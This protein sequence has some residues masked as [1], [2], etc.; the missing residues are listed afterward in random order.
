MKNR[1]IA[2]ALLLIMVLNLMDV[3]A[4]IS[5]EVPV[6]HIYQEILIVILSGVLAGYL[7]ISSQSRVKNLILSLNEAENKVKVITQQFKDAR[8]HYSEVIHQQF[9]DWKLSQSEQ[10]VAMLMLKGLNFQEIATIR[11]TKEKTCRQ[12]ASSIYAKSGLVGRHELSAW[13]IE[14]FISDNDKPSSTINN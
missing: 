4:D 8:H 6:W 7:I 11:N 2:A 5:L 1:I 3:I 12:Q 10:E 14:D 9:N 13:F